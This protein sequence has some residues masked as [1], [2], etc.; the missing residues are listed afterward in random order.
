VRYC[1]PLSIPSLQYTGVVKIRQSGQQGDV[2]GI[3]RAK[4]YLG[5]NCKGPAFRCCGAMEGS[6]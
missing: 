3:D 1:G 4:P 2:R 6:L 5:G